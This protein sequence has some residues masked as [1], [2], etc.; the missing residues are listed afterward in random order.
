MAWL[1]LHPSLRSKTGAAGDRRN[2]NRSSTRTDATKGGVA[3]KSVRPSAAIADEAA[4][5]RG[6]RAEAPREDSR[7]PATGEG[8][9]ER[10]AAGKQSYA[11]YL[12]AMSR[13]DCREQGNRRS[14]GSAQV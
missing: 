7:A 9:R 12:R 2:E 1:R 10:V 3:I 4:A 8:F 14:R 6:S 5:I 13:D 11:G